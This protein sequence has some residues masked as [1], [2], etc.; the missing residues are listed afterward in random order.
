[1]LYL[2]HQWS[3]LSRDKR[4]SYYAPLVHLEYQI[5]TGNQTSFINRL[6]ATDE[7]LLCQS[8][9]AWDI[10]VRADLLESKPI[11]SMWETNESFRIL[12]TL[13]SKIPLTTKILLGRC[14]SGI[15]YAVNRANLFPQVPTVTHFQHVKRILRL[16]IMNLFTKFKKSSDL[17]NTF[18]LSW[19]Q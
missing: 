5:L 7:L 16:T 8:K 9:Y 14:L 17:C 12:P 15:S 1:M 10:L 18:T 11:H 19:W 2:M 3:Y 4:D 13:P 6:H